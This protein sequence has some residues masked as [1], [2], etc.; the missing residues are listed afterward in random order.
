M[1]VQA[2]AKD[3]IQTRTSDRVGKR[4]RVRYVRPLRGSVSTHNELKYK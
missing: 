4:I 2:A 1:Y 3:E